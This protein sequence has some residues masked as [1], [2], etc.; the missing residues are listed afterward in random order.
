L[1]LFLAIISHL[2]KPSGRIPR[3]WYWFGMVAL[4]W[5]IYLLMPVV[6]AVGGR[7]ITILLFLPFYWALFCLMSQRSHDVGRSA[8][9]LAF[10]IVP[11]VGLLWGFVVLGFRRGDPGENQFGHDPRPS[12]PDYLVVKAVS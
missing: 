3:R 11:I 1:P 2:F 8:G 5:V 10:L 7:W 9:W 12:A 6:Q 4:L